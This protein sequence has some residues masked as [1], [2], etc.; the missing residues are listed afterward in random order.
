MAPVSGRPRSGSPR[1]RSRHGRE[2]RGEH[3]RVAKSRAVIL[4][5]GPSGESTAD[6]FLHDLAVPI[7]SLSRTP[8]RPVSAL[9]DR[10]RSDQRDS[11]EQTSPIARAQARFVGAMRAHQLGAMVSNGTLGGDASTTLGGVTPPE[12]TSASSETSADQEIG[13]HPFGGDSKAAVAKVATATP[14]TAEEQG[15]SIGS[16]DND[17]G[18]DFLHVLF[19]SEKSGTI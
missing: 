8:A 10:L 13:S 7:E 14:L 2:R 4:G 18:S 1:S 3:R 15:A 12:F 17:I 6:Q 11:A 19:Q 5:P 16:V 9:R